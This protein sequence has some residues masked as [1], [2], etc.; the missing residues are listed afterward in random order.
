MRRSLHAALFVAALAAALPHPTAA[1]DLTI[2][3]T[4]TT[5]RGTTRTQT[6]Y[7]SSSRMRLSGEDRDTIVD[8]T[9]GRILILDN[10]RKEYSETSLDELRAFFDQIDSAIAGR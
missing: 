2:I 8:L 4:V 10:Q 5:P 1:E 9:S 7:L 6:Q 3:S